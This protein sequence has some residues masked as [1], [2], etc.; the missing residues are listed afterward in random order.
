VERGS[1]K[2]VGIVGGGAS[3]TLVAARLLRDSVEP[4][5][6]IVFEPRAL[7]GQ[8]VAYSTTD[9]LHLL[10][11]PAGGM[12]ALPEDAD[13]FARWSASAATEFVPR[14]SYASYL[15]QVLDDCLAVAP[16]GSTFEHVQER[17]LDLGTEPSPWAATE[18]GHRSWFDSIVVASGHGAPHVPAPISALGPQRL[19]ADPWAPHALDAIR[20]GEVILIIG[21][22]LTCVDVSLSI[23]SNVP[24]ARIEA[25]SRH[26]LLPIAHEDPWRP[27]HDAPDW[28]IARTDLRSVLRYL[29]SFGDDWRRGLDSLRPITNQLWQAMDE[30]SK[31]TFLLRL[32]RYWDV[33][34][35]RMAPGVARTFDALMRAGRIR[36]HRAEVDRVGRE[37]TRIAVALS[38]GQT[39][40]VDRV[41]VC[42]GPSDTGLPVDPISGALIGADG[43]ANGRL[44][45]VGPPRKGVLWETTAI[46]EIR[47]QAANV[48]RAILATPV[49]PTTKKELHDVAHR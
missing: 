48:A 42:T 28:D 24:G 44:L 4:V 38:D 41:V 23:L 26:G 22:G 27:R 5:Q 14:C 47:V 2:R 21:T 7:L 3:G 46:P 18:S 10:N 13:H 33:H 31:E 49:V 30:R 40:I 37:G 25:V 45:A 11:V 32:S 6:V 19:V 12:S 43:I 1:R 8:G 35:H 15:R 17:V 20:P 9:P 36:V 29:R 39:L 16:E 34:R